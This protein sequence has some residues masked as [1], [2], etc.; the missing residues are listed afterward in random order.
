MVG[1]IRPHGPQFSCHWSRRT[2]NLPRQQAKLAPSPPTRNNNISPSFLIML[3]C[4]GLKAT[5]PGR[6]P[7]LSQ[8]GCLPLLWMGLDPFVGPVRAPSSVWCKWPC[9]CLS[10]RR[11]P[12][13]SPG[14]ASPVPSIGPAIQHATK[15]TT[16]WTTTFSTFTFSRAIPGTLSSPS[17]TL[18]HMVHLGI[19]LESRFRLSLGWDMRFSLSNKFLGDAKAAGSWTTLQMMVRFQKNTE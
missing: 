8:A 5:P 4:L 16:Y 10:K 17:H 3:L 12:H 6:L 18:M 15:G 7:W 2:R 1:W 19:L 9:G 13:L 11:R 14:N